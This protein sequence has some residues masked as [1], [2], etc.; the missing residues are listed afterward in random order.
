M[1]VVQSKENIRGGKLSHYYGRLAG[2]DMSSQSGEMTRDEPL[3]LGRLRAISPCGYE[4]YCAR[5]E[6]FRQRMTGAILHAL[7]PGDAWRMDCESRSEWGGIF[8]VHLRLTHRKCKGVTI[9]ILSP[10]GESPLW[11]G[12]MW[13]V[14]DHTRFY[15]WNSELFDP[16]VIGKLLLRIDEMVRSGSMPGDI[17]GVIRRGEIN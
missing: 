13:L 3:T 6:E 10:G 9:D 11:H 12:L 16:K 15:F 5:S 4:S 8:P 17:A 14:P 7:K 2:G 1:S